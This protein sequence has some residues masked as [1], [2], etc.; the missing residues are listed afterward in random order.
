MN[1]IEMLKGLIEKSTGDERKKYEDQLISVIQEEADAKAETK[2]T[3]KAALKEREAMALKANATES[4]RIE[5]TSGDRFKGVKV[6]EVMAKMAE[7]VKRNYGSDD[8]MKGKPEAA[9]FVAT[10]WIDK[11]LGAA[12]QKANELVTTTTTLGGNLTPTEQED[13]IIDYVRHT[14][15]ALQ[16]AT[17]QPMNSDIMTVP[18][19]GTVP[20]VTI[21]SAET[22]ITQSTPTFN[23]A[24]LTSKRHSGYIPVSWELEADNT[25]NLASYLADKFYEQLGLKIDSAMFLGSGS[26]VDGSGVMVGYGLSS[27][28]AG[29]STAFSSVYSGAVFSTIA[30]LYPERRT[31]AKIYAGYGN[32]WAY[33]AKLTYGTDMPLF[34][35]MSNKLLGYPV[36]ELRQ[37]VASA[38]GKPVFVIGNLKN[39]IVGSRL[40]NTQLIKIPEKTGM[41]N[42]IFF[43]R[44]AYSNPL[45]S[46]FAACQTA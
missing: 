7:N 33:L 4:P 40:M 39:A 17:V 14:S 24:T 1:K 45:S 29:G 36:R 18:V 9:E 5:V 23:L 41:T 15:I 6:K 16:D 19:Q 8:Y 27:V 37:S 26:E 25:A 3:E 42:F 32:V 12:N 43:T 20:A 35:P 38:S 31:G 13:A 44:L 28:M 30:A 46:A 34:D 22:T 10:F 11:A 21:E 2:A